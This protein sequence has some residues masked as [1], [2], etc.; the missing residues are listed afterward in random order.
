MK[1]D[2]RIR[3]RDEKSQPREIKGYGTWKP[4]RSPVDWTPALIAGLEHRPGVYMVRAVI[5]PQTPVEFPVVM[6]G[7]GANA[8]DL[9]KRAAPL[10][11]VIYIGKAVDLT[12]RFGTLAFSWQSN[13]PVG[14][15][16]SARNY[17]R[18]DGAFRQQFPADK[19]ELRCMPIGTKDWTDKALAAGLL[20]ISQ[21]WFWQHYPHWTQGHGN[22]EMDQ[23]CAAA[24]ATERSLLCLYYKVFGD[25]PPLNIRKPNMIG[26]ELDEAWLAA[27]NTLGIDPAKHD[28]A[29]DAVVDM[30]DPE[31]PEAKAIIEK[32]QQVRRSKGG[33]S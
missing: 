14:A 32:G 5:A 11:G 3:A 30:M 2:H 1:K 22:S 28:P 6:S 15:H 33:H 9:K 4:W 10:Q 31:G 16:T 21:K 13:P 7:G 17:L 24:I 20:D 25:F 19:I 29:A 8:D 18:K 26:V 12:S 23:T 27:Y